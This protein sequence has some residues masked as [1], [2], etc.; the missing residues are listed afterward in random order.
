MIS[1]MVTAAPDETVNQVISKMDRF[2]IKEIPVIENGELIGMVTYYDL[3]DFVRLDPNEKV[4]GLMTMPP[5]VVP[6]AP[7]ENV[8]RL[9]LKSGVEGIPVVEKGKAKGIVS[10]FDLVKEFSKDERIKG[11]KVLDV[12]N[13][14]V[15]LIKKDEM[16]SA[17]RRIMRYQRL[18]R[19]P[20]VDDNGKLLGMIRSLDILKMF[21]S[22]PKESIGRKDNIGDEITPLNMPVGGVMKPVADPLSMEDSVPAALDKLVKLELKGAPVVNKEDKVVGMFMRWA[23]LDKIVERKF[24]EGV[25]LNFS[26][27]QPSLD[28]ID[29]IKNYVSSDVKRIKRL[30]TDL[31]GINVHIK[32]I[33]GA[34]PEKWNYEMGV[35]L[36]RVGKIGEAVEIT[37]FNLMYVLDEALKKIE[38]QLEKKYKGRKGKTY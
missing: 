3:L 14:D 34:T 18:D 33:H 7:L 36:D 17:A 5:T 29:V 4:V 6:D 26:G 37:G 23:I 9:M 25:W 38:K 12:M 2:G 13:T 16:V 10:D 21:F 15:P 11:L 27:F 32:T 19:L 30:A 1:K 31:R 28:S 22:R 35:K 8:A 24:D 20:I